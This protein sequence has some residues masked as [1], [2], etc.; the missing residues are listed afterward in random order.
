MSTKPHLPLCCAVAEHARSWT[1]KRKWAAA[2]T[3]SAFTFI[4]PVSS[5]MVAPAAGQ[6]ASGFHIT[7]QFQVNLTISVF[8]L[9]YGEILA[10]ASDSP[11]IPV[12]SAFG[13]LVLAPLCEVF[14]RVPILRGCNLFFMGKSLVPL[15]CR[16]PAHVWC[17]VESGLWVRPERRAAD[18]VPF[19]RRSRRQRTTSGK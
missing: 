10:R 5:S 4:S 1:L 19:P 14:G 11:L 16:L 8:V 7:D 3:V 17:S 9:A 2:L 13:P 15:R 18:R 12:S 6:I